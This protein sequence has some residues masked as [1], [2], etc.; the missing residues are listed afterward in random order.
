MSVTVYW[1]LVRRSDNQR[2]RFCAVLLGPPEEIAL[3]ALSTHYT[4]AAASSNPGIYTSLPLD[5]YALTE[6]LLHQIVFF[7]R[8]HSTHRCSMLINC[9][10]KS[11]LTMQLPSTSWSCNMS[12]STLRDMFCCFRQNRLLLRTAQSI[13]TSTVLAMW[14]ATLK[15]FSCWWCHHVLL[16]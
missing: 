11:Y 15:Q 6:L 3:C 5:A 7:C 14:T 10:C 9:A 8:T 4:L 1:V 12:Q 13:T 2:R 16:T